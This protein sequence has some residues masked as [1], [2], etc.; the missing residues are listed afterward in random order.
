VLDFLVTDLTPSGSEA[1]WSIVIAGAFDTIKA[2]YQ[3]DQVAEVGKFG[4]LPGDGYPADWDPKL[5]SNAAFAEPPAV[6]TVFT[7]ARS[8]SVL[9]L[10]GNFFASGFTARRALAFYRKIG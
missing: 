7:V 8:G 9:A 3:R 4:D 10:G 2:R 1:R 5:D 6:P